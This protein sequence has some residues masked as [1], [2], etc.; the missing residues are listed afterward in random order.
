MCGA[1]TIEEIGGSYKKVNWHRQRYSGIREVGVHVYEEKLDGSAKEVLSKFTTVFIAVDDL[2][3]RRAIQNTCNELGVYHISVGIGVEIEGETDD[4]LGGMVKVET[5]LQPRRHCDREADCGDRPEQAYGIVQTAE[6]NMLGAALAIVEWKARVGVYR[7]RKATGY[8]YGSLF[9]LDCSHSPRPERRTCYVRM[10]M[11]QVDWVE[12]MPSTLSPGCL[13]VSIKHRLTEHLCACGCGAEVSLPL[14][15]AEWRIEYDGDS[16]SVRPSIGNWRL[17]C[18]SHYMIDHGVTRWCMSWT[19][20]EVGWGRMRDRE[21]KQ[22]DIVRKRRRRRWWRRLW[23]WLAPRLEPV[24]HLC[25][26]KGLTSKDRRS[27]QDS[28][29]LRDNSNDRLV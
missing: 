8:R 23:L 21:V 9:F 7:R 29:A 16:V 22:A 3:V 10:E 4:Q 28:R 20:E 24:G 18:R 2:Q 14:G 17:P 5:A 25:R 11:W 27:K 26:L 15:P 13:Y 1:P 12:E 19:E 6:L